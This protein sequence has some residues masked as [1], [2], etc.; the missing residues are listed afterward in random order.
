MRVT[1]LLAILA[2]LVL[3]T[4]LMLCKAIADPQRLPDIGCVSSDPGRGV[5]AWYDLGGRYIMRTRTSFSRQGELIPIPDGATVPFL[6][7]LRADGWTC[8][9]ETK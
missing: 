4:A 9:V 3:S 8:K 7:A 6:L 1:S 5:I 2:A